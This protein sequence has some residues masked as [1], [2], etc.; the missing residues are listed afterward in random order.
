[1]MV[2]TKLSDE[3]LPYFGTIWSSFGD[4]GASL[5]GIDDLIRRR[6]DEKA[7]EESEE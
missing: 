7:E 2:R 5:V 4:I 6:I 1:M 3:E